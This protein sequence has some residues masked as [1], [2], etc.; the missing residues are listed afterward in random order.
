MKHIINTAY[1]AK[2]SIS[3]SI[4]TRNRNTDLFSKKCYRYALFMFYFPENFE[5]RNVSSQ[6]EFLYLDER[7]KTDLVTSN[8]ANFFK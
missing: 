4:K 5:T 6:A 7:E 8:N 1:R 2:T 3:F